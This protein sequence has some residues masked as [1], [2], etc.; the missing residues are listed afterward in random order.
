MYLFSIIEK[1]EHPN[2][3]G[4]LMCISLSNARVAVDRE[5]SLSARPR[6]SSLKTIG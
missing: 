3:F 6:F 1:N 5:D 2:S 4:Q